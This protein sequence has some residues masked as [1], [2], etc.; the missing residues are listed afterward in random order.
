MTKKEKIYMVQTLSVNITN[1]IV[2]KIISGKIPNNWE[3]LE[4]RE[5]LSNKFSELSNINATTR[6]Y[7]DYKNDVLIN[8]I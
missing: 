4:L 2:D 3:G 8:L 7:K 1:D 6:R 5:I